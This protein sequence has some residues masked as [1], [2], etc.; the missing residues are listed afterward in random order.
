MLFTSVLLS[1]LIS[2]ILLVSH[3][4]QNKGIVYLVGAIILFSIRQFAFLLMHGDAH[5]EVLA[6]LLFHFDPLLFLA[7]PFFLYYLK[8]LVHGKFVVDKYLLVYAIP[9]LIAGINTLPYFSYPFAEKV[10]ESAAIQGNYFLDG[11]INFST[12][13][14]PLKYQARA[15]GLV[16]L[17]FILYSF[18]YL[19]RLK[20]NGTTSLKKKLS[21]LINRIL[22]VIPILLVSNLIII[23][24]VLFN[25][26]KKGEMVF[27]LAAFEDNGA[28]FFMPLLLP[29]SFLLLPSWLYT[30]L[31]GVHAV[32]KIRAF[33]QRLRQR[34]PEVSIA[35]KLE[36]SE[37]LERI[38]AYLETKKPYVKVTFSLH[39][40]SQALNIPLVRVTTCFNKELNTSFPAYR[41][42]LRVA[43]AI[44]L[45][46]EGAHLSTSI[47]GVGERSGFKSKS[48][49]YAA[50]KEEYGTTP[51]EWIKSNL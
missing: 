25:S 1:L 12:V 50:F 47:E 34:A 9:A 8:S 22:V 3:W 27:R 38:V 15:S 49:F 45:L 48:I 41:N 42:K 20:K 30:D 16:N 36:K 35:S 5:V 19:I 10:A 18:V 39:D 33:F 31:E 29:L 23:L 28:F 2:A 46:R 7:G 17:V 11:P 44:S 40:I 37:D 13:F 21:V 51:S 24:Y 4:S 26:P 32:D 43:H 6:L 14:F